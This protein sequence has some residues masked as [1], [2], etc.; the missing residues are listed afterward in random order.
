[1]SQK[2]AANGSQ[3]VNNFVAAVPLGRRGRPEEIASV[4]AF[5]ASEEASYITGETIP[6]GG[7]F[8]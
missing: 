6:V 7:G 5:L 4:A 1:M 3:V 2:W 8:R